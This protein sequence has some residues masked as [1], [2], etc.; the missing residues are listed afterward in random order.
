MYTLFG[1]SITR[2][3]SWVFYNHHIISYNHHHHHKVHWF[4]IYRI[5]S[6]IAC[7][8]G[9]SSLLVA[10]KSWELISPRGCCSLWLYFLFLVCLFVVVFSLGEMPYCTE[11]TF[12]TLPAFP[13][14]KVL[15]R[16]CVAK[17]EGDWADS[18]ELTLLGQVGEAIETLKFSPWWIRPYTVIRI[19]HDESGIATFPWFFL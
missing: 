18:F 12:S 4:L 17:G 13:E 8:V 10:E 6:N 19:M 15:N 7:G 16:L 2:S 11:K 3:T 14:G 5:Q 1:F 9:S